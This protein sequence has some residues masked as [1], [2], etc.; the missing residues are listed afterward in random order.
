L[1]GLGCAIDDLG[2]V[3]VDEQARTTVAGVYAA[4]DM[5]TLSR[6][7]VFAAAQGARAGVMLH[8]ELSVDGWHLS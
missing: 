5:T 2:L 4:G 8:Y 6:A 1:C 3:K 7:V